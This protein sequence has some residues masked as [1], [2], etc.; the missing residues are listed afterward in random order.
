MLALPP[1]P[2]RASEVL[3]VKINFQ[4]KEMKR[5]NPKDHCEAD[6][7]PTFMEDLNAQ[8]SEAIQGGNEKF[9]EYMKITVRDSFIT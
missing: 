7:Q 1:E 6:T 2:M 8:D 5:M 3:K 9:H 4:L